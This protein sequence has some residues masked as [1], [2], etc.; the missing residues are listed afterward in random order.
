[1]LHGLS[2]D[3]RSP[4]IH[5]HKMVVRAAGYNADSP[6]HQSLAQSGAVLH[7]LLLVSL[8]FRLQGLLEAHGLGGDHMH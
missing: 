1:M 3:S 7:Q 2:G 5:Q 4:Q 8:E 6:A